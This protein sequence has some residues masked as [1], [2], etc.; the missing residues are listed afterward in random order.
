MNDNDAKLTTA[1]P[2]DLIDDEILQAVRR[3][4]TAVEPLIPTPPAWAGEGGQIGLSRTRMR[5]GLRFAAAP[6]V[7]VAALIVIV[8]GAGLSA[9]T[10]TPGVSRSPSYTTFIYRLVPDAGKTVT[11]AD[12]DATANILESRIDSTGVAGAVVGKTVDVVTVS[13]PG[14]P[15]VAEIEQLLGQRGRL[16]FVLLPPAMYGTSDSPGSKEIPAGGSKLDPSLPAQFSAADLDSGKTLAT[17]DVTSTDG[18]QVNFGFKASKVA[19]FETWSG[20]H[21]N[22]YFAIAMDGVVQSVPYIKTKLEGGMGSI[23]GFTMAQAKS[24]A[25]T[26]QSGSLPW[27]LELL[28]VESP[29]SSVAPAGRTVAPSGGVTGPTPTAILPGPG[30]ATGQPAPQPSAGCSIVPSATSS[31]GA[32]AACGASPLQSGSVPSAAATGG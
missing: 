9:R 17:R 28:G 32:V 16:E 18:W 12:L 29:D 11:A 23:S 21:V 20:E 8:V 2:T 31:S 22:D 3:R 15:N 7:L 4:M 27:P 14:H 1:A 24:L 19:E 13:V 5:T 25:T 10:A 26:L 6:L 30:D